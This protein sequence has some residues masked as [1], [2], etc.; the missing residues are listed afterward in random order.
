M[1]VKKNGTNVGVLTVAAFVMVLSPLLFIVLQYG[2][3]FFFAEGSNSS[4]ALSGIVVSGAFFALMAKVAAAGAPSKGFAWNF[5]L[6]LLASW[7][8]AAIAEGIYLFAP[9]DPNDFTVTDTYLAAHADLIFRLRCF[10]VGIGVFAVVD[11]T[12]VSICTRTHGRHTVALLAICL[13][14]LASTV[15][16]WSDFLELNSDFV[17]SSTL[18][19]FA[20]AFLVRAAYC[21]SNTK[22]PYLLV[23]GLLVAGSIVAEYL[24]QQEAEVPATEELAPADDELQY[25][26]LEFEEEEVG[27]SDG[28]DEEAG[29]VDEASSDADEYAEEEGFVDE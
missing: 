5:V 14:W 9:N 16:I 6:L 1:S 3:S 19:S 17:L 15:S 29:F 10:A 27:Y 7:G 21:A 28:T 23:A 26:N 4:Y 8:L 24:S 20:M 2:F 22:W 11:S 13:M 25:E 12:I 18:F